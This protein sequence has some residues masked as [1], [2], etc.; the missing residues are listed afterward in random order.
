MAGNTS[1]KGAKGREESGDEKMT[2]ANWIEA[3]GK[4][5][6]QLNTVQKDTEQSENA[7]EERNKGVNDNGRG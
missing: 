5:I 7:K 3:L 1:N 2:E 4:T 6:R